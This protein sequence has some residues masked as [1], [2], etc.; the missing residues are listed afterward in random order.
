MGGCR[1][2]VTSTDNIKIK[3]TT[4]DTSRHA[5]L[6]RNG[7]YRFRLKRQH[8]GMQSFT[9]MHSTLIESDAVPHLRAQFNLLKVTIPSI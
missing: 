6:A 8:S 4:Q 1:C 5:P 9:V 7:L 3:T 2:R